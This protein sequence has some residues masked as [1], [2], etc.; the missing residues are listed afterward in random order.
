[1]TDQ[2]LQL[3]LRFLILRYGRGRVVAAIAQLGEQSVTDIEREIDK[4]VARRP[5]QRITPKGA[6]EL[7][8]GACLARPDVANFLKSLALRYD[9]KSFLPQ[10]REVERFLAR[11]KVE[12][13]KLK[14]RKAAS[15]A[16]VRA[17]A[18]LPAEEL[19]RLVTSS[20]ST[21]GS[22]YAMLAL[23]IMGVRTDRS[24]QPE[25]PSPN[26]EKI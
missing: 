15:P 19:K 22:E 25:P 17:L 14:S 5:R 3:E 9:N 2:L 12:H 7:V 24:R 16:V 23:E 26:T 21:S 6:S 18:E 13:G 4:V 11:S 20:P 1:M 10:L 8:A